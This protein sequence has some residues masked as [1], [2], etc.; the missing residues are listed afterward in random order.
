MIT[1]II[2]RQL[3]FKRPFLKVWAGGPPSGG[4]G[5]RNR[6]RRM[7]RGLESAPPGESGCVEKK[8]LSNRASCETREPRRRRGDA[9][10]LIR[11]Q[12]GTA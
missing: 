4:W 6:D 1:S 11:F 12:K 10:L 9:V 7:P 5:V 8:G 2:D 3:H